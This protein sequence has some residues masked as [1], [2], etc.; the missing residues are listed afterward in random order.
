[1]AHLKYRRSYITSTPCQESEMYFPTLCHYVHYTLPCFIQ[2]TQSDCEYAC[3]KHLA[4]DA[5][6][7]VSADNLDFLHSFSRAFCS[8]QKASWHG[9]T[10][11]L[12]FLHSFSHVFCGNQK[13]SWHGTTDNLDFLH[14]FSHVFCGN[15]KASWH[16]T[17]LQVVQPLASLSLPE[18]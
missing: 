2:H 15:Q 10:D 6:T 18:Y 9:T 4:K 13:A 8:N 16:G 3:L 11:N 1:M 7:D 17:T 5:F 12:D 14:S